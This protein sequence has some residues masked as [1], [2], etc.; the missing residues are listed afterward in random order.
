MDR[1]IGVG[2]ERSDEEERCGGVEVLGL[3]N[4]VKELAVD[5]FL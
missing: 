2:A 4:V 5:K 1:V 3:G